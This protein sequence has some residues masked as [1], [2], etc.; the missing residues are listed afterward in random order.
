[1]SKLQIEIDYEQP[2]EIQ[3]EFPVAVLTSYQGTTNLDVIW[4]DTILPLINTA[5]HNHQVRIKSATLAI[6]PGS[7]VIA[8]KLSY[9][10]LLIVKPPFFDFGWIINS[11]TRAGLQRGLCLNAATRAGSFGRY[12]TAA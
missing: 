3:I 2:L 6:L 5:L 10:L 4:D 9:Q 11:L 7:Q 1:V 8:E 12:Y